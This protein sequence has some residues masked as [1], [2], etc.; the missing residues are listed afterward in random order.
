MAKVVKHDVFVLAAR[1]EDRRSVVFVAVELEIFR[2]LR[3]TKNVDG[4]IFV[5]FV[6]ENFNI[7]E[8]VDRIDEFSRFFGIPVALIRKNVGMSGVFAIEIVIAERDEGW[9]DLAKLL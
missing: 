2:R 7:V 9:S 4:F 1:V 3:E 8:F 5:S 6:I